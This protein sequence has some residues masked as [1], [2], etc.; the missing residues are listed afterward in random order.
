M[1]DIGPFKV[2]T[3][4][5][6]IVA[7]LS[8][9]HNQKKSLAIET[10]KAARKAGA[11]AIKLQTYTPDTLTID[12]DNK[13]FQIQE[14]LWRGRKLYDLY[15]EAYTPWEWHEELFKTAEKE[16]L[17]CFS[18][19][20][21]TTAVDFLEQFNPPVYKIAS[22]EI[23]DIPLIEYT[24]NKGKPM[25]ISTGIAELDDIKLAVDT[26]RKTGNN[27]IILLKCTSSY[28]APF[29]EANLLTIPDLI[30]TFN[31][32]AGLSDH[33]LGISVPIAAVALGAKVI[34]KHFI[35][36]RKL[37][38][39]D[40]AFSIEPHELK[41]MVVAIR[42]TEKAIGSVSYNLSEKMKKNRVFARSLFIVEDIA[43]GEPLTANNI[44]S[45][46]PGYGLHPKHL[47]EILNK[48][49]AKDLKKGTP[50]QWDHIK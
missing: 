47:E 24:A 28:P 10:I 12:C 48:K 8:A 46:R 11:D 38:G 35:L 36:D 16:G 9:N 49:T 7:E 45:I 3:G 30:R 21:D 44:R 1:I 43:E 17:I 39:P 23:Q 42:E 19:P 6:F 14:G 2:G 20:F 18:T 41:A 22:F 5:T 15:L 33:T 27:D 50:L 29:E 37:G 34:E 25:I 31:T 26:I 4:K 13:F 40:A 32:V